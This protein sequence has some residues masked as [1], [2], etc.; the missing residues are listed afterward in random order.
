MEGFKEDYGGE[1]GEEIRGGISRGEI[2]KDA[3][4]LYGF[5]HFNPHNYTISSASLKQMNQVPA[6][7]KFF[8]WQLE[9]N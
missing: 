1:V 7:N 9:T 3:S 6:G 8:K 5:P 2:L 4:N